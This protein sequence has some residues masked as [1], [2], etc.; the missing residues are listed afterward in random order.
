MRLGEPQSRS[1][2]WNREKSLAPIGNR[3]RRYTYNYEY[4]IKNFST[5][6]KLLR[7]RELIFLE[8]R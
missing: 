3:T 6:G 4:K 7:D 8:K 2:L 1:K 5:T